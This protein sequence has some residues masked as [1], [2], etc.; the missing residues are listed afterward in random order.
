MKRC[1]NILAIGA[2]LCAPWACDPG[3]PDKPDLEGLISVSS[4]ISPQDTLFVVYAHR[5][6]TFGTIAD[7]AAAAVD[8]AHVIIS[9]ENTADTLLFNEETYRY[10][11]EPKNLIIEAGQNYTLEIQLSSGN[12]LSA[13]CTVPTAPDMP[14]VSGFRDE[15]DYLFDLQWTNVANHPYFALGVAGR[16]TYELQTPNGTFTVPITP[17]LDAG[18][19]VLDQQREMN[20]TS[21]IARFA[22]R[23]TEPVLIVLLRNLDSNMYLFYE[24]FKN[25]DDW[26]SNNDDGGLPNFRTQQS[27]YSNI[28]SGVGV[29]GAYNTTV[30]E[31]VIE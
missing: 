18:S 26:A 17:R 20:T 10:E 14:Q 23:S 19:F 3:V 25:A 7:D 8:D 12:V 28:S 9:D 30:V 4:F 1:S 21:G 15:E 16:G 13:M 2:V 24:S 31:E 11:L 6:Q 27:V 22:Y 29:F 5:V